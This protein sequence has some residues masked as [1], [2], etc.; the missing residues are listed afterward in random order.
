MQSGVIMN[1]I[2]NLSIGALTIAIVGCLTM[3]FG[4]ALKYI[5]GIAGFACLSYV[6]FDGNYSDKGVERFPGHDE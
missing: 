2:I 1:F 4:E 6:I 5:L 3:V